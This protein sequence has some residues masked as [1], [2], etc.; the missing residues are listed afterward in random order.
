MKICK[1]IQITIT[2]RLGK[3][4]RNMFKTQMFKIRNCQMPSNNIEY[5][6]MCTDSISVKT[7]SENLS[8]FLISQ[9]T[10]LVSQAQFTN[11]SFFHLSFLLTLKERKREGLFSIS[12][13]IY[14]RREII[15]SPL[16]ATEMPL[17]KMPLWKDTG[18]HIS[19]LSAL[20]IGV[21]C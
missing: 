11:C 8:L 21:Y 18:K 12:T 15:N 3:H 14:F 20:E 17:V 10:Q 19:F 4:V 9:Q 1:V 13:C 6:Y 7:T 2:L 5:T 16:E